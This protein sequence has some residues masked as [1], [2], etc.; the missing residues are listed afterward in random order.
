[1]E[2]VSSIAGIVLPEFPNQGIGD[3]K[4]AGFENILLDLSVYCSGKKLRSFETKLN[5]EQTKQDFDKFI[6]G[7]Q[8]KNLKVT[9]ALLPYLL[10]DTKR[11]DL[12][13]LLLRIGK[14]SIKALENIGCKHIIARPLYVGVTFDK[15]WEINKAYYLELA[16]E[17][18]KEDTMILLQNQCKDVNGHLV[19]GVCSDEKIAVKWIDEL[20]KEVGSKRFGF[21]LDVGAC[22]LCG[23][24]MQDI[25]V[26]LGERVK[27]ILVSDNNGN[28]EKALLPFTSRSDYSNTTDWLSLIRG[29]RQVKF[30][31]Q[32]V[33]DCADTSK[34]FSAILRPQLI[35]LSKSIADYFKWQIELETSL[36]KYRSIVLFGAGNM[37]RNFMKC[38]GEQ[39]KPLFTC[40]NNSSIWGTEFCGLEVKNPEELK[41][42]PKDCGVYICNMYYREIEQQLK[43]LGVENIEFFNDEYLSSYYEDRLKRRQ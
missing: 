19:R 14:D 40:D 30:D 20:N 1:M 12:N 24:N 33:I 15:E 23:Q 17:C 11:T 27:T 37:C 26:T 36:K 5:P 22:N 18:K 34:N 43:E 35:A 32:L 39:Y 31:G 25:I 3:I 7:I 13:E 38:Y 9:T 29:L 16:K 2:I 28:A 41:N 4:N 21:C 10:R 42:L 8:S 6:K